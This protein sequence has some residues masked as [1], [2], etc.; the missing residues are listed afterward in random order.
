MTNKG[1]CPFHESE[2]E[3]ME[4]KQIQ[5]VRDMN[6]INTPKW[7]TKLHISLPDNIHVLYASSTEQIMTTK[8]HV[9]SWM[10]HL[11]QFESWGDWY[12]S[13]EPGVIL[14]HS[15]FLYLV[16]IKIAKRELL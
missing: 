8:V 11:Y 5:V 1:D 2:E 13:D 4:D 14:N 6:S 9:H 10:K 16:N 15:I 7:T 3:D 12:S